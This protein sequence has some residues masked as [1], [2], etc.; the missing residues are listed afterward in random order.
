MAGFLSSE[1]ERA[2]MGGEEDVQ[3]L[4]EEPTPSTLTP[5]VDESSNWFQVH[6]DDNGLDYWH[7]IP[8]TLPSTSASTSPEQSTSRLHPTAPATSRSPSPNPSDL[9]NYGKLNN[10]NRTWK[11]A[12]PGCNS[13]AIF[14]R[15]CDLRKHYNRHQKLYFCR[16]DDCNDTNGFSSKKDR[17]RHEARHNPGVKCEWEGCERIFSR[18][19][20]M[21]DH[22]KRSN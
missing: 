1:A 3:L 12:Y 13:K 22:L 15:P 9:R 5:F 6:Q 4:F 19:D 7:P 14:V 11:C 20:N 8:A 17:T 18:V 21:R 16:H 10:D 2:L